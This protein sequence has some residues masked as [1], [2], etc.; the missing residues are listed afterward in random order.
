MKT[1]K[2]GKWMPLHINE[3]HQDCRGFPL[4]FQ[5]MYVNLLTTMWQNNGQISDDED[6]LMRASGASK[7]QW[8]KHR[9]DLANLFTPGEGT[10]NHNMIRDEIAKAYKISE[11]KRSAINQRWDRARGRAKEAA[12]ELMAKIAK[13][14][15]AY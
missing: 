5:A 6:Y 1:E 10:W 13:D 7:A 12:D 11:A 9:Q 2:I 4:E 14:G 8:I 3:F 15:S